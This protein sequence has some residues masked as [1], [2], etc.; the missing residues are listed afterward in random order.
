MNTKF[1]RFFLV[2]AFLLLVFTVAAKLMSARGDL[3]I[4]AAEDPV[5]GV[6]T[7]ALLIFAGSIE[8][9][10][11]V[12]IVVARRRSIPSLLVSILGAQFLVYRATFKIGGYSRGCPCLGNFTAWAHLPDAEINRILWGI[13]AWLCFGGALS[14]Y[15]AYLEESGH[16][17][18]N[19]ANQA[20]AGVLLP[21]STG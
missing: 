16:R 20:G 8:I 21:D 12:I 4:L 18:A 7:R 3:R 9:A 1:T 6:P 2:S 15:L 14:F 11:A 13:A 10:A 17:R 19:S 5:V